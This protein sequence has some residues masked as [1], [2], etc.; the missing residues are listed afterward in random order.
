MVRPH[1][2]LVV[3]DAL[4]LKAYASTDS[5]SFPDELEAFQVS[6]RRR[7]FRIL[8]TD[9]ILDQYQRE[10][11][12]GPQFLLQPVLNALNETGTTIHRD[13]YH[14]NRG[15]IE[16]TGL[17][18]WHQTLMRDAIAGGAVYLITNWPRWLN[19]SEQTETKYGL[20]IVTPARFVELE[21]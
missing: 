14:L 20:S 19:L 2:R 9:G 10:A 5:H 1:Q 15:P 8:L 16:L 18:K 7:R 11:N 17:P 6:F 13:E 4:M 3:F 21:G 12:N